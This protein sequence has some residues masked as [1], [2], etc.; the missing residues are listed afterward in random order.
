MTERLITDQTEITG[1][2]TIKWQ[3]HVWTE[4]TL[5]TDRAVQFANAKTHVYSDS[6]RCLGGIS[7]E[8]VNAWESRIKLFLE[9]RYLKDLDGIDGEPMEFEWKF[10]TAFT[11][12][13]ILNKIQKM[14]TKSKY[15]PEQFKGRITMHNDIDWNKRG[16]RENCIAN[17]HRFTEYA[18]RFTQGHWS[19]L[20]PG[21][22]KK[23][24]GTHAHKPDGECD[25]T[26]EGMMLNFAGSG[27]PVFRASS[28]LGKR[29][30]EKQRKRE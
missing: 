11:T 20:G 17:I 15:E 18:R 23:W 3:Q 28:A 27:H 26:G 6:V 5:L 22:E 8:P 16:N 19:I 9:T 7:D 14:M 4:T 12:F 29:R 10:F 1:L 2:T 30:N 21:S 24:Y 13:E 25:K